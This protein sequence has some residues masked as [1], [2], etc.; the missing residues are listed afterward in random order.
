MCGIT[1]STDVSEDGNIHCLKPGQ[2]AAR[3]AVTMATEAA[4]L[5]LEEVT[6]DDYDPFASDVEAEQKQSQL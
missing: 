1:P 6:E 3:A 4:K 5:N 2:V